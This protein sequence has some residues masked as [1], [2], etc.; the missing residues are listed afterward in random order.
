M[1]IGLSGSN[2]GISKEISN[3]ENFL[4]KNP[5][6]VSYFVN[7]ICNLNCKHCY[8]GYN[9]KNH[10]LSVEKW[11]EVFN[12]LIDLGG[13]TFGNVGKEPLLTWDKTRELL[14]FFYEK[15]KENPKLRFGLV[16]NGTLMNKKIIKELS[17]IM[18]NYI[19][20]S[21]DGPKEEHDYVRGKEVYEKVINNL[22]LI[23]KINPKLSNKIFISSVLMKHNKNKFKEMISEVSDYGVK[24]F[25]ISPYIKSEKDPFGDLSVLL[26]E[27]INFYK[28]VINGGLFNS[29]EGLE[30]ILK[31]DYDTLKPL[32]DRCIEEGI[33]DLDNLLID[34]YTTIFNKYDFGNNRVIINYIPR[35]DTFSKE[36]RISHDGFVSNCYAQFFQ[37]YP[38]RDEVIGNV[39]EKS[40]NKILQP[41]VKN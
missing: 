21:L 29:K 18:P 12:N 40:I 8:V 24:H 9:E 41:Y 1:A 35:K 11:K 2:S 38:E 37:D 14:R 19:D 32:M 3:L 27:V 4:L 20:V 22:K 13:L 31:N 25:L 33:I 6:E 16:T 34:E 10:N 17:E 7:N 39:K 23:N 5:L 30:I 15:R 36:I 28:R 26:K